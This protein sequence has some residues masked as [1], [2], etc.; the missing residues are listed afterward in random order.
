MEVGQI[1]AVAPKEK[2]VLSVFYSRISKMRRYRS[3]TMSRALENKN[4]IDENK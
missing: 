3:T 1:G 4:K 2:N